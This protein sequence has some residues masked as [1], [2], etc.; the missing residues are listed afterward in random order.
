L[1][2]KTHKG[3]TTTYLANSPVELGFTGNA[4]KEAYVNGSIDDV[5]FYKRVL[6]A[7]EV[8]TLF[9]ITS[10]SGINDLVSSNNMS[11]SPNPTSTSTT[12][13]CSKPFTNATFKLFNVTG[14]T[15]L[16]KQNLSG[17]HFNIDM[18]QQ[19]PGIYFIEIQQT[20]DIWRSK[21]VKQ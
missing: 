6:L 12:I 10:V 21:I 1:Q 18:S 8:D 4:A 7:K 2:N 15:I 11:I 13:T 3:F 17:N 20:N 14:Q 5:R 19:P 9:H 16:E